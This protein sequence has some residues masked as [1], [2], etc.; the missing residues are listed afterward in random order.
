MAKRTRKTMPKATVTAEPGTIALPK[1]VVLATVDNDLGLIARGAAVIQAQ[2]AAN[3]M[4]V[5]VYI[6]HPVTDAV[7]AT[8]KPE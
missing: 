3:E 2:K 4:G 5:T 6:R 7:L 8:V 1:M